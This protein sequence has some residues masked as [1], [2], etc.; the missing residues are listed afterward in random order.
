MSA[1]EREALARRQRAMIEALTIGGVPGDFDADQ[2]AVAA[3]SLA[4]KRRK[5]AQQ[6]WPLLADALGERF[7]SLFTQYAS[8][9]PVPANGGIDDA[10]GLLRF[11]VR[12]VRDPALALTLNAFRATAGWPMRFTINTAG[13]ALALR[14]NR[15]RVCSRILRFSHPTAS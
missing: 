4:S 13:V 11:L 5:T 7:E 10:R 6:A 2:I 1:D 3:R 15:G 9:F 12:E 8:R 14:I